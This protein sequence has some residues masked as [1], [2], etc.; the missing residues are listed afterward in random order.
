[1]PNGLIITIPAKGEIKIGLLKNA[2]RKA[3]LTE[4][5]FIGLL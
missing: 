2:I 5:E 1:M 4:R 3:G